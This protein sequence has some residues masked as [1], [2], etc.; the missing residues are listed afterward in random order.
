[1]S[2]NNFLRIAGIAGILSIVLGLAGFM[3]AGPTGTPSGSL[4]VTLTIASSLAGI[5]FV[6][7]LYL[8]FRAEAATLSLVA[9]GVSVVGGLLSIITGVFMTYD[10]NNPL[11]AI[12][13]ISI[14]IVG[15]G[16]FTWLG[17]QSRKMSRVLTMVGVLAALSGLGAYILKLGAGVDAITTPNAPLAGVATIFFYAYF[18]LAYVWVLWTGYLLMAGKTKMATA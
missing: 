16:L 17:Y 6:V 5:I 3:T 10:F 8:L 15:L 9:V 1:M 7:G 11:L 12:S 18:L 4:F 2:N 13:D 14:Y